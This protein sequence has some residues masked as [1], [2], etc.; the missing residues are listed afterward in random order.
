M[1]QIL[2]DNETIQDAVEAWSDS[3]TEAKTQVFL[4]Y[5]H[6]SEWNTSN[7]TNMELLLSNSDEFNED[8]SQ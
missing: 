5:G 3:S 8:I 1:I 2:L 6:I 4:R 7:V